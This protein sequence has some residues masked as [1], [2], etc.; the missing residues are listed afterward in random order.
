MKKLVL[1]LALMLSLNAHALDKTA[2]VKKITLTKDNV[3]VLDK[4]IYEET[5]GPVMKDAKTLDSIT[6]SQEPI[7][8]FLNSPGG[9]IDDGLNMIEFLQNLRRPVN[10]LSL[11]SASMAFQTVQGLGNRYVLKNGT[12]MSHKARGGFSG[13]FPGQLD[14][15]Y[16]YYLKRITRLDEQAVKRTNGKH[17]LKSYRDLI[18]NE[19]WCDGQDC[20]DQG[21][22]DSVV[23]A[24][25]DKSLEG[26]RTD[27]DR[28][29]FMGMT[30]QIDMDFA[31]CP[32]NPGLLAFR[33]TVDGKPLFQDP[34]AATQTNPLASIGVSGPPSPDEIKTALLMREY[35]SYS[36]YD[37]KL[38]L[39]RETMF[40]LNRKVKDEVTKRTDKS[41]T[42]Y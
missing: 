19:Y 23:T 37:N 35:S 27:T 6:E 39:D 13:E 3:L 26:I 12:L 24:E 10:T 25:C 38:S 22:A 34:K 21:F 18:E 41:V 14:S 31:K 33:V 28:F 7:Y 40:E 15:R 8:L 32:L 11:F 2:G 9:S 29:V 20:V 5:V 30:I 42:K 16:S 17:T 4:P 1:M 36:S